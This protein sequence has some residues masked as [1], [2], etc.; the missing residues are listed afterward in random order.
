[1]N[2][3]DLARLI[4]NEN[5]TAGPLLLALIKEKAQEPGNL[6]IATW[7]SIQEFFVNA[8][9]G[10]KRL[11]S[12]RDLSLKLLQRVASTYERA[13]HDNRPAPGTTA[14]DMIFH[15]MDFHTVV[16]MVAIV[17]QA[18]GDIC[19][20]SLDPISGI[21]DALDHDDVARPPCDLGNYLH[22]MIFIHSTCICWLA[23]AI[24]ILRE[25]TRSMPKS[26]AQSCLTA[27]CQKF[28]DV[29]KCTVSMA[30]NIETR[31]LPRLD[32]PTSTFA[33]KIAAMN[34]AMSVVDVEQPA[35]GPNW[36]ANSD[37]SLGGA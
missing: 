19:L 17:A 32:G 13:A 33:P 9:R 1:M 34:W 3:S 16:E 20:R 4:A 23:G 14:A 26:A 21:I 7:Q 24:Y 36:A 5:L 31:L 28:S 35:P 27:V 37:L 6:L 22:R 15:V 18:W 8:I 25:W 10:S 30:K 29:V 2:Y 12:E 11:E